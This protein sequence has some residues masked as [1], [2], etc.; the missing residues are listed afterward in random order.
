MSEN[1]HRKRMKPNTRLFT[2]ANE[3]MSSPEYAQDDLPA[4]MTGRR[5]TA[6]RHLV[7]R[8]FSPI[9]LIVFGF[10]LLLTGCGASS[11]S[12]DVKTSTATPHCR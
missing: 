5:G 4:R 9:A 8:Y 6:Q 11:N 7:L 12:N 3:C 2:L 10:S 1:P